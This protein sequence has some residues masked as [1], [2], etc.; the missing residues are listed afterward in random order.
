M[1]PNNRVRIRDT[2]IVLLVA[3]LLSA[4]HGGSDPDI[5]VNDGWRGGD[6]P[7]VGFPT[8]ANNIQ[9]VYPVDPVF[10]ELYTKLGGQ[11]VLGPAISPVS[12]EGEI[13]FQY[14]ENALWCMTKR[15]N[16]RSVQ[17][18]VTGTGPDAEKPIQLHQQMVIPAASSAGMSYQPRCSGRCVMWASP[19]PKHA[20]TTKVA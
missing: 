8:E 10:G 9:I 15:L 20:L 6:M 5:A 4:C 17:I 19:S 12:R 2:I 3:V 1:L 11:E 14:V 7:E 16:Q 18:R 13:Q